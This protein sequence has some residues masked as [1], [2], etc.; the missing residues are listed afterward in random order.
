MIITDKEY[1]V[2]F[3]AGERGDHLGR[4]Y[5]SMLDCDDKAMEECHDQI[6]WMFPLHEES[7]FGQTYPILTAEIVEECKKNPKIIEN[8]EKALDRMSDFYGIN[9]ANRGKQRAWCKE[10]N[11]NLLRITRIIRSVRMLG[12]EEKAKEFHTKASLIANY[13]CISDVTKAYWWRA[14]VEDVWKTLK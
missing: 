7:N 3:L 10:P 8:I 6:Q 12:A 14:G 13:F 11:H 5:Q 1:I 2:S 9:P 4:S